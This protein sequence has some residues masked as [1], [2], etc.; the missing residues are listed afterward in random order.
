MCAVSG[1]GGE[2]CLTDDPRGCPGGSAV[3]D[4]SGTSCVNQCTAIEYAIGC[5]GSGPTQAP[6]PPVACRA[7]GVIPG[8]V[9][10]FCCP[11]L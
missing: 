2:E 10:F 1:G 3:V 6:Q 8:G 7:V 5:G 9:Q 11:C 4:A